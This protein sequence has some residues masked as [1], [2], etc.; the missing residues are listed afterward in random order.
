[1]EQVQ[2][3]AT[4]LVPECADLTYEERCKFLGIQTL[5]AR[6][7]RG[8]MIEVY[9]LLGG[10]EDLDYRKFFRLSESHARGEGYTRGHSRKLLKP[11]HWRTT[12]KGNWFAI[13]CV[14]PWNAL[15]EEVISASTIATF[16]NRYDKHITRSDNY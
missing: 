4:L 7:L 3:R 1:M 13:R 6:R 11:D 16:K 9:K 14:D 15:R 2:R 8:D 12:L 5:Q 10:L